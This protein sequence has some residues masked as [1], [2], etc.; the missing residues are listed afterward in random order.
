MQ[1][2]VSSTRTR[3]LTFE[4]ITNILNFADLTC[5]HIDQTAYRATD[6]NAKFCEKCDNYDVLVS[7]ESRVPG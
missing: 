5:L 4:V 6:Q 7:A 2:C 1:G 3:S